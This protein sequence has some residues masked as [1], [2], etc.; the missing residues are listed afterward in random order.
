MAREYTTKGAEAK[1]HRVT[2]PM[3]AETF[4]QLGRAADALQT[5]K[6][7]LVRGLIEDHLREAVEPARER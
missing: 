3:K 6:A 4:Q 1:T 5:D 2:V 7:S